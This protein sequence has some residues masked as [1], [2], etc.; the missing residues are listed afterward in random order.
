MKRN[1]LKVRPRFKNLRAL[2]S[3]LAEGA[4]TQAETEQVL[5]AVQM[6]V[7]LSKRDKALGMALEATGE[8]KD[9]PKYWDGFR[10]GLVLG[11]HGAQQEQAEGNPLKPISELMAEAQAEAEGAP[12]N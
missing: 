10:D 6:G 2:M 3:A 1:G 9:S 12:K 11:Y 7:G 4:M 8:D 5:D